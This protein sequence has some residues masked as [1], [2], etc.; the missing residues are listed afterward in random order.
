MAADVLVDQTYVGRP[1]DRVSSAEV[2]AWPISRSEQRNSGSRCSGLGLAWTYRADKQRSRAGGSGRTPAWLRCGGKRCELV[3]R[4]ARRCRS[5]SVSPPTRSYGRSG[6]RSPTPSRRTSGPCRSG[7]GL[8]PPDR[9]DVASRSPRHRA[10]SVVLPLPPER[11]PRSASGQ[12][13]GSG[14]RA[15]ASDARSAR[16]YWT[17]GRRDTR[18]KITRCVQ[19]YPLPFAVES[20]SNSPHVVVSGRGYRGRG[21]CE[22]LFSGLAYFGSA[23]SCRQRHGGCR[24]REHLWRPR[25]P[26]R[27]AHRKRRASKLRGY[28]GGA[29]DVAIRHSCRRLS[30]RMRYCEDQRSR[31]F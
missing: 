18:F 26:L 8:T 21:L 7:R 14:L 28:D 16:C 17:C 24:S 22:A 25:R 29:P 5:I 31:S 10:A 6:R 20:E 15:T 11:R 12:L 23:M 2:A 3:S 19:Q 27:I 9:R 4:R 1:A 30:Q 13:P